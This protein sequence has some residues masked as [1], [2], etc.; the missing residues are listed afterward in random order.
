MDSPPRSS[1]RKTVLAERQGPETRVCSRE[2]RIGDGWKDG[3]GTNFTG[4]AK[5]TNTAIDQI[6]FDGRHF[7]HPD[8][9]IVVPVALNRSSAIECDFSF[10]SA[11]ESP[12]NPA[13]ERICGDAGVKNRA[14]IGGAEHFGNLDLTI[15]GN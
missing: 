3:D 10:E 6:N 5:R 8:D 9:G 1:Q 4:A 2:N 14:R 11:G 12:G 13:F 7:W 15:S